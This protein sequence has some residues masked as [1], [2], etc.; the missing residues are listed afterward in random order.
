LHPAFQL[1]AL[2]AIAA[3]IEKAVVDP[4]AF[5]PVAGLLEVVAVFD[6]VQADHEVSGL[7]Q[8]FRHTT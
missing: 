7:L 3:V 8:A 2:Q 4:V 5:K 6:S 1:G